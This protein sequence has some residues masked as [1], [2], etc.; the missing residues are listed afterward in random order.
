M[1][2]MHNLLKCSFFP[3]FEIKSV[4]ANR[5]SLGIST[6]KKPYV[7]HSLDENLLMLPKH[8]PLRFTPTYALLVRSTLLLC[9]LLDSDFR[10]KNSGF[11]P[12]QGASSQGIWMRLWMQWVH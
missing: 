3:T 12:N 4:A 5:R 9:L 11:S 2:S 8:S 10:D 6:N 7:L 1:F